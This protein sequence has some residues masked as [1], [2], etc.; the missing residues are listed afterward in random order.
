MKRKA[1]FWVVLAAVLYTVLALVYLRPVWAV[2]QDRIAPNTEDP[3]FNLW[4]LKWSAHQIRLGLPDLWNANVY[5]PT[6]GTL[7]LSDHL[8]GPAFQLVLFETVVP[9]AIAG[10]NFLFF[11]SF[12]L[13]GL[14]VCWV[15]RRSGASWVA[16]IL[17]GAMYAFSPFRISQLNH[18]QILLAQ[19]VPL[20]LWFWDRL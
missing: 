10:Y 4:V 13:T 20:T 19:W 15:V 18:I 5:W 14:A 3:L 2:W 8:L 7:T 12:V 9:N 16:A 17:A 6:R 1:G 11:T